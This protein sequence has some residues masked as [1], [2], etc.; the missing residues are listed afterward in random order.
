MELLPTTEEARFLAT[1]SVD[2]SRI[3]VIITS[4]NTGRGWMY[5][6]FPATEAVSWIMTSTKNERSLVVFKYFYW[7]ILEQI[8]NGKSAKEKPEDADVSFKKKMKLSGQI[9]AQNLN[10][11]RFQTNTE[12]QKDY[13]RPV[14]RFCSAWLRL[15]LNTKMG[16]KH[17]PPPPTHHPPP[18]TFWRVLGL[19]G[20]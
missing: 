20:G 12:L 3:G 10:N 14:S 5:F 13:F 8:Y 16:F 18:G 19:L 11:F 6:D 7:I 1:S 15:K 2:W 4:S 9:T 17:N